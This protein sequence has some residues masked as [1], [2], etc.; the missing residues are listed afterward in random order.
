MTMKQFLFFFLT[1]LTMTGYSQNGS[2]LKLWYNK[3]SGS[4]WENALPIGNGKLGAMIYGNV[5][6]EIIQL[7]ESTVW[8]GGPNR[9]D[10]PLA[11]DSLA[12]IR[13]LIFAGE[14]K[15]AEALA[16]R[17]IISKKSQGQMFEP[18]GSLNL[19][20]D[21]QDNYTNYYR[22]LDIENA[23]A[24]TSYTVDGIT[25]TREVLASIPD[26]VIVMRLTASK[27]GRLS[28]SAYFSTPQPKAAM[29]AAGNR[30]LTISG[31]TID[32]EKVEGKIRFKGIARFKLNG[33]NITSNDTTLFIKN[34]NEATIY[35]SIATNFNNFRDISGNENERAESYL[36]KAFS[37]SFDE[38]EKAHIAAYQKY[39]NRVKLDLGTTEAAKLPTDERLKNFRTA[40]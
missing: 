4:S 14:Q 33:G 11:L 7:N 32:H 21:G 36:E 15:Q 6:S 16:N 10:N 1:F 26:R 37:K 34:A 13:R 3:P 12:E 29:K 8:S 18:V 28:F 31:V 30:E 40:R 2:V 17:V 24:K 27:P 9:N 38:I 5:D 19:V 20:F 23:V 22:D 35:I 39:F 25:Y